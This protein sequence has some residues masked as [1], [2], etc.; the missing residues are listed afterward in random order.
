[1]NLAAELALAQELAVRAGEAILKLRAGGVAAERKA[2]GEI[3][4]A[5]DR[6][7]DS[8]IRAGL[9][10]AFPRDGL[11]SEESPAAPEEL[12][13]PRV[14]I[15]DPID[16]TSDYASGGDEHA[17][18]IGL[19]AQGRAVLG[20]VY[21][22]ARRELYAGGDGLG[23]QRNGADVHVSQANRLAD[24]RLVVSSK[25]WRRGLDRLAGALPVEPMSSAAYK[26]A[27]VAAGLHDGT[28]SAKSRRVWDVCGGIALLQAAGGRAT[29]L[30]GG[31]VRFDGPD[32]RLRQGI[33]A[34]GPGLH[35]ALLERLGALLENAR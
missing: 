20:V 5:A 14:W 32:V 33:V 16:A 24:A 17:V 11:V 10:A 21:N 28:F 12:L 29:F 3:V 35:D 34:S 30:D 15:V 18:S 9:S 25:E 22:P 27:R 4:T 31:E 1:M 26:L 2:G 7:A 23:V 8:L 6:E 19:A 13:R